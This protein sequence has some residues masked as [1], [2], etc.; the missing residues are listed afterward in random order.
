MVPK[1]GFKY[2]AQVRIEK[3]WL[4]WVI[5]KWK[6]SKW[7]GVEI[8]EETY[9]DILHPMEKYR[10]EW[11]QRTSYFGLHSDNEPPNLGSRPTYPPGIT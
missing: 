6:D 3:L 8:E 7:W 4:I 2:I 9:K 5:L 1:E 10:V 11:I